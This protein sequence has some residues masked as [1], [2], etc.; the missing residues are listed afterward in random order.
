M[1]FGDVENGHAYQDLPLASEVKPCCEIA[2]QPE[3]IIPDLAKL[4]HSFPIYLN[5]C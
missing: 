5:V 4:C 2:A 3:S 1:P